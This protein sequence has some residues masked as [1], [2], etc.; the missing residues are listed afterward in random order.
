[1]SSLIISNGKT[2]S[3]EYLKL[4][5]FQ[6]VCSEIDVVGKV[7]ASIIDVAYKPTKGTGINEWWYYISNSDTAIKSQNCSLFGEHDLQPWKNFNVML[8]PNPKAKKFILDETVSPKGKTPS[9]WND[10]NSVKHDERDMIRSMQP[11]TR[12]QI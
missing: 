7:L 10:Y 11:I 1:M 3:L 9:W 6:A 2:Y 8:N 5:Q 12:K 4:F